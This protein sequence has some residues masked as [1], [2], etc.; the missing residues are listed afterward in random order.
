MSAGVSGLLALRSR[1]A[2]IARDSK[3]VLKRRLFLQS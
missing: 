1:H 2:Q 3:T